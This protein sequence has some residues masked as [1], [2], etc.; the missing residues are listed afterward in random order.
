VGR[1]AFYLDLRLPQP[2][3]ESEGGKYF[4]IFDFLENVD[5]SRPAQ[6]Q[7]SSDAQVRERT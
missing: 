2:V 7:H 1:K 4:K 3:Q 6:Q 5:G